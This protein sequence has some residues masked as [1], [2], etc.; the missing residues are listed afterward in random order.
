M[1]LIGSESATE[2]QSRCKGMF[3]A[4]PKTSQ[5]AVSRQAMDCRARPL[6]RRMLLVDG[7]MASQ[8]PSG[9]VA[10]RPSTR[11]ASSSWMMPTSSDCSWSVSPL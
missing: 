9:S 7:S 2:P 4:L 6:S 5:M 1:T 8:A 3:T 10:L 11:G